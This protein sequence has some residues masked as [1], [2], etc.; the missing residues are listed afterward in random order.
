MTMPGR[1]YSSGSQYRF[2][3]QG[4]E[5]DNELRG[6]GNSWNYK[7][8]M[9]DPRIGRFFAVDPLTAK[10]PYLTPYQFSSNSV[11]AMTELEGLEGLVNIS[12]K[13]MISNP[14]IEFDQDGDFIPEYDASFYKAGAMYFTA[15]AV[16]A[17]T[18]IAL[19]MS[20]AASV[21]TSV[22]STGV[23]ITRLATDPRTQHIAME[24]ASFVA[25]FFYDGPDDVFPTPGA[26]GELGKLFSK[27]ITPLKNGLKYF[28]KSNT[29]DEV[30]TGT[31][32]LV[33]GILDLDFTVPDELKRKGIGTEM[34]NGALKE[35]GDDVKGV[36][37]LWGYN[38]KG[39]MSDN[40][41]T[42]IDNWDYLGGTMGKEA[43][44]WTTSTGKWAKDNGYDVVKV[45]G[46]E[47][48][49]VEVI[50]SKSKQ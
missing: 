12:G 16:V 4:Q 45:L 48:D 7:Y 15:A 14:S 1:S 2:G 42:F 32:K 29:G 34:F 40:L 3:F 33:D 50:F 6:T 9:H 43:A 28:F 31:A 26:G 41:K 36:R 46:A 35:F 19:S 20:T 37:G 30:S 25:N 22:T 44:A 17:V 27:S 11:V 24:G 38:S 10:Y 23:V 18:P 21:Y 8:R 47:I 39:E 49:E 5:A 13:H